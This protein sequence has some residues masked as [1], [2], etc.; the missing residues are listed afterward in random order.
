MRFY[1]LK[2]FLTVVKLPIK[3]IPTPIPIHIGTRLVNTVSTGK[4][5]NNCDNDG[6]RPA[7]YII[8]SLYM[9]YTATNGIKDPISRGGGAKDHR[10]G[11]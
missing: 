1:T 2:C 5:A 11:N 7:T 6:N 3:P 8:A 4:K 9:K 10:D